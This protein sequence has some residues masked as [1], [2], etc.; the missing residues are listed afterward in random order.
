[1]K[2]T[3]LLLLACLTLSSCLKKLDLQIIEDKSI[4]LERYT[5]STITTMHEHID[6]TNKR[7]HR[8]EKIYEGNTGQLINVLLQNDSIILQTYSPTPVIYDLAAIK[9]G[10]RIVL[11]PREKNEKRYTTKPKA[12]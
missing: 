8:T 4:M 1:M 12:N 5:T 9:Y 2:S 6:I 10:Y 11:Q 7:W 3:Y